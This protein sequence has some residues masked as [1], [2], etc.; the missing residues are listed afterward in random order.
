MCVYSYIYILNTHRYSRTYT[1]SPLLC[2]IMRGRTCTAFRFDYSVYLLSQHKSANTDTPVPL[3][4]SQFTRFTSTTVQILTHLHRPQ[5][6]VKVKSDEFYLR[7]VI[8]SAN[9][10]TGSD[11]NDF[12]HGLYLSVCLSVRMSVC[13]Y[14]AREIFHGLSI[15]IERGREGRERMK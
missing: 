5:T 13:I 12:F 2:P 7:A 10:D 15:Y 8:G 6:P 11:T 9:F 1:P 14:I 3:S 4:G